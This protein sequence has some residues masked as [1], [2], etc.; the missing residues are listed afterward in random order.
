MLCVGQVY[1]STFT[2]RNQ[3]GPPGSV[4][5]AITRPDGT[6]VTPAPVIPGG[7]QA[8]PDWAVAYDYT[9]ADVGLHRFGWSSTGPGT[10]PPPVFENVRDYYTIIG[11][12]EAH[13]HLNLTSTVNDDELAAF[14]M[15]A[16]ELVEAKVGTCVRRTYTDRVE[17]GIWR[18]V[19]PH[20]PILAVTSVTST[21]P[22]GPSWLGSQL[23]WDAEAGIVDQLSPVQPFWWPPW[24]VVYQVGRQVIAERWIHAAKEQL[25][26]LWDTQR[27]SA[28]PSVLQGEE[29]FTASTGFSFS[30]PRRVLEL[31]EQDI[32]PSM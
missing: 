22:G 13:D 11:L 25:R 6:L 20:R 10:A 8:G 5:L 15:A 4:A 23:R 9:M 2:I 30:V 12:G 18:L 31:L 32:V 24:D 28:A 19:L 7:S 16:T 27:G 1:H 3:N 29:I 14:S 17:Q 26:H 21:W